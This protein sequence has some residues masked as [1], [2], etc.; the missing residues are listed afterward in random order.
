MSGSVIEELIISIGLSGASETVEGLKAV[1]KATDALARAV[2]RLQSKLAESKE[3]K[4][5]S[6]AASEAA[7]DAQSQLEKVSKPKSSGKKEDKPAVLTLMDL[8]KGKNADIFGKIGKN[9]VVAAGKAAIVVAAIAAAVYV[10]YKLSK[11]II[12]AEL[13]LLRFV[14]AGARTSQETI[15]IARQAGVTTDYLLQ[16]RGAVS[17]LGGSAKT[18]DGDLQNLYASMTSQDPGVF[19]ETLLKMGVA[20]FTA[21]GEVRDLESVLNDVADTFKTKGHLYAIQRGRELGLSNDTIRLLE[22]GSKA[23]GE[24]RAKTKGISNIFTKKMMEDGEKLAQSLNLIG[25]YVEAIKNAFAN[26][27]VPAFNMFVKPF[28]EFFVNNSGFIIAVIQDLKNWFEALFE[29]SMMSKFFRDFLGDSDKIKGVIIDI[30]QMVKI[31]SLY[32]K[33]VADAVFGVIYAMTWLHLVFMDFIGMLTGKKSLI[34]S[35]LYDI[36][37]GI[38]SAIASAIEGLGNFIIKISSAVWNPLK[39]GFNAVADWI[40]E[41][42]IWISDIFKLIPAAI[43]V[44]MAK[45]KVVIADVLSPLKLLEKIPFIKNMGSP[46]SGSFSVPTGVPSVSPYSGG[47]TNKNVSN[48][49]NTSIGNVSIN[50]TGTAN[51]YQTANAV[52]QAF[53]SVQV[54]SPGAFAPTAG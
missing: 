27:L 3:F 18:L 17:A 42:I 47:T 36:G 31:L 4:E 40:A 51:P 1:T 12:E 54:N 21:K 23:L 25:S 10:F 19:N 15:N 11:A 9:F 37:Y 52:M 46:A 5:F 24:Y 6:K 49:Q 7:K 39:N 33:V 30:V 29:T 14:F 45:A 53:N 8:M 38:V 35:I 34:G 2:G 50:V 32:I 48:A 43:Q 22:K 41:K 44:A 26:A 28:E 16:M 13:A 20:A